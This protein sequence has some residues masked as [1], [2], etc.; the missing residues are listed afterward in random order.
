M[1]KLH[2]VELKSFFFFSF[3]NDSTCSVWGALFVQLSP[4]VVELALV[5]FEEREYIFCIHRV[6][7]SLFVCLFFFGKVILILICYSV[8]S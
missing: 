7:H 8:T 3:R 1:R 5:V 2:V 4:Q 6:H